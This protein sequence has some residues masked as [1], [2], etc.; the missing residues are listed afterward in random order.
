MCMPC[1]LKLKIFR[2]SKCYC[3]KNVDLLSIAVIICLSCFYGNH[4]VMYL[5][6]CIICTCMYM[7]S[8]IIHVFLRN[9]QLGQPTIL[10]SVV[11]F[12]YC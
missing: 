9:S 2:F 5:S 11:N 1:M 12:M 8:T 4:V 6:M 3:T 7:S 10:L